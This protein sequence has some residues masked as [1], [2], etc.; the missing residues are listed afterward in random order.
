MF[1]SDI[2]AR[3]G[4]TRGE[5][6]RINDYEDG[7]KQAV[8]LLVIGAVLQAFSAFMDVSILTSIIPI[9]TLTFAIGGAIGIFAE[10]GKGALYTAGWT[11]ISV[12]LFSAG[13]IGGIEFA[14]D[15]IPLSV[16]ILYGLNEIG[17]LTVYSIQ[18]TV[19]IASDVKTRKTP[20]PIEPPSPIWCSGVLTAP[21]RD[22]SFIANCKS[23]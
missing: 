9:I 17:D 7:I 4:F 5:S 8:A 20:Q 21:T 11:F 10:V 22:I 19:D 14:I 3:Y 13:A 16:L 6:A 15:S 12:I 1:K 23:N 18:D 2:M